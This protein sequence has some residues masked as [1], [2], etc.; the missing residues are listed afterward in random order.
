M[1]LSNKNINSIIKLLLMLSFI[2]P[3]L[4]LYVYQYDAFPPYPYYYDPD[5][6]SFEV[7]WKGRTFYIFFLWIFTLELILSWE[8]L[9]VINLSTKSIRTFLLITALIAPTL[10]VIKANFYGLN[11]GI[12]DL[13]YSYGIKPGCDWMPLA[14]EY[15]VLTILFALVLVITYGVSGIAKTSMSI[16]LLGTIGLIYTIDNIYP[17]GNFT[18]FQALIPITALLAT[19]FLQIIGYKV[20]WLGIN[21][22]MPNYVVVDP[23][24]GGSIEFLIGW[25]CSG[26][27]SLL[28][29]ALT[30]PLFLRNSNIPRKQQIVY[31]L[32][33]AAV[34]YFINII[35][36]MLIVMVGI[37]E[38][39]IAFQRFHD[40]YGPLLPISWIIA[41]PLI[42]I[43]TRAIWR[44]IR[45]KS[46]RD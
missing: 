15:L 41:Y 34:T 32:F 42:I 26:I 16:I 21:N 6:N 13:I 19:N 12:V 45:N 23:V 33:G 27:E 17:E 9:E 10:Y 30:I 43:G 38:G 18:P 37:N 1:L 25:P 28:I 29:Y 5:A 39:S 2:T 14:T 31:F 3:I 40:F 36:I 44:K 24:G 46:T 35:R 4:I 22:G 11:R 8:E 20:I 7:L